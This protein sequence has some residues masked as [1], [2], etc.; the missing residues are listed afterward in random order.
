MNL[1]NKLAG[2]HIHYHNNKMKVKLAAQ[3]FSNSVP[4]AINYLRD[5]MCLPQFQN[6]QLTTT[7]INIIDEL[8]DVCNSSNPIGVGRK[9]LIFESNLE[10]R[11]DFLQMA[12]SYLKNL[13]GAN[14]EN[15]YTAKK[16]QGFLGFMITISSL[17]GDFLQPDKKLQWLQ[18]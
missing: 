12:S 1:A 6:S 10:H 18:Q 14:G 3:T 9:A 13:K 16:K 5:E 17:I 7:F 2:R 11:I 15:M 8:F 4:Q